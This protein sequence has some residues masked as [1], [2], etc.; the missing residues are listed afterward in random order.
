M[1]NVCGGGEVGLFFN[2]EK[3]T[4]ADVLKYVHFLLSSL[5]HRPSSQVCASQEAL[6]RRVRLFDSLSI[7]IRGSTSSSRLRGRVRLV[8][9]ENSKFYPKRK[10]KQKLTPHGV[11]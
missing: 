7:L 6:E 9:F 2:K 5:R 8:N 1:L 3:V 10:R 4:P 11:S